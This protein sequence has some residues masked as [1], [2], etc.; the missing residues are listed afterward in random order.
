MAL[1]PTE[2]RIS[3]LTSLFI[4][5]ESNRKSMVVYTKEDNS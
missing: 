4:R 2:T 1:K 5:A 3:L